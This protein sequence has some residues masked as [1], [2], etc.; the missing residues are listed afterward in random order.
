MIDLCSDSSSDASIESFPADSVEISATSNQSITGCAQHEASKPFQLMYS[1]E[2]T[3]LSGLTTFFCNEGRLYKLQEV[4]NKTVNIYIYIATPAGFH[5]GDFLL[6]G[7]QPDDNVTAV[8]C[9][10]HTQQKLKNTFSADDVFNGPL[11]P[12]NLF[13]H[14]KC[15]FAGKT[16]S[17]RL[18]LK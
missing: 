3:T 11:S 18:V 2:C 7:E 10:Q 14:N 12:T 16:H 13:V 9:Q 1:T 17:L 8:A 5:N 6:M 15:V 4:A